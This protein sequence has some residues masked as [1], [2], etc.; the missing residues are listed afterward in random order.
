MREKLVK[1]FEKEKIMA[2]FKETSGDDLIHTVQA[3]KD[4]GI[5]FIEVVYSQ[6]NADKSNTLEAIALLRKTFPNLYIGCGTVLNIEQLHMAHKAGAQFAVSPSVSKEVIE[7]A[8]HL[9]MMFIPGAT[10]ATEVVYAHDECH[11]DIIKL[12]PAGTMGIAYAKQLMYPLNHVKL[13]ATSQMSLTLFEEF[14][15]IGFVGAGLRSQLYD[16]EMIKTKQFAEI[17]KRAKQYVE[18]AK[19]NV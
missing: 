15:Q 13:L 14:L 11:A 18:I 1:E 17:T 4:G 9:D 3:L 5:Q 10:T 16:D 7:E 2:I 19:K 6:K 12:F 8:H